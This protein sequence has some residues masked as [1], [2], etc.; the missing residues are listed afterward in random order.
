MEPLTFNPAVFGLGTAVIANS[1]QGLASGTTASAAVT[2]LVPAGVDEVSMQ[3]SM[4]FATEGI[5]SLMTNSLAQEE[6]ARA[7]AA[8]VESAGIYTATDAANA[9]VLI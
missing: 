9:A 2:A 6:L 3:A 7:G 4:A 5:E 8:I 1:V